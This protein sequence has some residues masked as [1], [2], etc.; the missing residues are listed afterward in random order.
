MKKA[1]YETTGLNPRLD[2][3]DFRALH[4]EPVSEFRRM[5]DTLI[6]GADDAP[7]VV[8]GFTVE[9]GAVNTQLKVYRGVAIGP[10]RRADGVLERGQIISEGD[11]SNL[12][13]LA[14][15]QA[16]T[17]G[18]WIRFIY[19]LGEQANR[20]AWNPSLTREEV[21]LLKTRQLPLWR[22]AVGS[23]APPGDDWFKI[24]TVVWDGTS[25]DASD[26]TDERTLFFEG[27]SGGSGNPA[28]AWTVPDFSRDADRSTHGVK[29][30]R[31]F[32]IAMEKRLEELS[33]RAWYAAPAYG[34]NVRSASGAIL[35]SAD[36]AK[37][38]QVHKVLSATASARP[39]E[40]ATL[41]VAPSAGAGGLDSRDRIRFVPNGLGREVIDIDVSSGPSQWAGSTWRRFI[42]GAAELRRTAGDNVLINTASLAADIRGLKFSA[43]SAIA[44]AL[45][46]VSNAADRLRFIGCAFDANSASAKNVP[47]LITIGAAGAVVEFTDCSF[48]GYDDSESINTR[49]VQV[50]AAATVRFKGCNFQRLS[51]CIDVQDAGAQLAVGGCNFVNTCTAAIDGEAAARVDWGADNIVGTGV[52]TGAI[53]YTGTADGLTPHLGNRLRAIAL[54]KVTVADDASANPAYVS[55][56]WTGE[57]VAEVRRTGVGVYEV[58]FDSAIGVDFGSIESGRWM[59]DV[60]PHLPTANLTNNPQNQH[61]TFSQRLVTDGDGTWVS[62]RTFVD[63]Y[64]NTEDEA[65]EINPGDRS[66]VVALYGPFGADTYGTGSAWTA[67]ATE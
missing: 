8:S 35:V 63:V 25:V 37:A 14:G 59:I 39:A 19:V 65:V 29:T 43:N 60:R 13:S 53:L 9:V 17:L 16:G 33:G 44:K 38:S 31:Q 34:E 48:I 10:E 3:P 67:I 36:S 45:I 21:R 57:G 28:T 55:S 42:E 64:T 6:A 12:I 5:V 41:V 40:L 66:L 15:M 7:C 30:L 52:L 61:A 27:E 20:A 32:V 54:V 24:A 23:S 11:P 58:R 46:A 56:A 62:V 50:N 49:G 2:M 47:A 22:A 4:N 18:V 26:I 1:D 51:T